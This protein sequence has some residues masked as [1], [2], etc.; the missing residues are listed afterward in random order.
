MYFVYVLFW[1]H[2]NFIYEVWSKSVYRRLFYTSGRQLLFCVLMM[3]L[4]CNDVLL[5]LLGF[6]VNYYISIEF[7]RNEL[8][9]G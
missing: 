4:Q 1:K 7:G 6:C 5:D 9:A 3:L 8:A 2:G